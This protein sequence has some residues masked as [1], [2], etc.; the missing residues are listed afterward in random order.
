MTCKNRPRYDYNVFSGT[1]N[2]SQSINPKGHRSS[3]CLFLSHKRS[4]I[5][6]PKRLVR[7][8]YISCSMLALSH[9]HTERERDNEQ[10]NTGAKSIN[11]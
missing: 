10:V 11:K 4:I 3:S 5:I 6:T 9:T 2:L 1:L 8:M 7:S